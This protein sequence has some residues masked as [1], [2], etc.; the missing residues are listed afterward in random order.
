MTPLLRDIGY[1]FRVIR[2]A[3]GFTAIIVLTLALG[4]GA[5][6]AIFSVVNAVLL[7]PFPF[8][9]ADRLV[10]TWEVTPAPDA[11]PMFLS[12][13]NYLDWRDLNRSLDQLAAFA[14]STFFL[15][16]DEETIR[17]DGTRI[18][19]NLLET[20]GVSPLAGRDFGPDDDAPDAAPV[21]LISYALWQGR[22]GGDPGVVGRTIQLDGIAYEVVGVMGADFA[23]PPPIDLEGNTLPRDNDVWVPFGADMTT[24]QRSAHFVTGIGRLA[25]GATLETA[26]ADLGAVAAQLA[27]DWPDSNEGWSARVVP[28][29]DVVLGNM[30]PALLVLLAAVTAVLLIACVNV[31]NLLLSRATGRQKEYAIRAALG[32]RRQRLVSQA[33]VESQILA[34]IGGGAGIVLA[35]P[36]TR[37]LIRIAPGNVPRLDQAG[38]DPVVIGWAL[39]LS[40][41]TGLLYGLAPA[42]RS[43]APDLVH[44]LKEG[45]R[46]SVGDGQGRLRDSLV[47]A[48]VALSLLLL[49]GAGLLFRSFLQ[50]RGIDPGFRAEQVLTMR[51][52][53]PRTY[54]DGA[55][56]AAAFA[57]I[58]ER[59]RA[60]PGV[61]AAGFSLDLPLANDY[62]GTTLQIEGD[63]P[64]ADGT[65]LV[66]FSYVT[67]GWFDAMGIPVTSGRAIDATDVADSEPTIVINAA[68]ARAWFDGDPVGRRILFGGSRRVVGVVGDVRLESIA[69]V[70][71]PAMYVPYYQSPGN[72][73]LSLVLRSRADATT[74][75]GSIR[76]GVRAVDAG[77]PISDIRA[78]DDVVA[79][80]LASPRFASIVLIAFSLAALFL[81]AIGIYGVIS[82]ATSVRIREIGVRMALGA[83]PADAMTLVVRHAL[84]LALSGV[85]IGVIASLVFTR[86]LSSL[87]FGVRPTDPLTLAAVAAFLVAVAVVAGGV[88]AWK[89]SR[90]D[91]L[92]ALRSE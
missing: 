56:R 42:V 12:P 82:Y 23:F 15:A 58:E 90:V 50:L 64:P 18:S 61:D 17:V 75:A 81:A 77:I 53:L 67:P 34:L 65:N 27:R 47:I 43:F 36:A 74:L 84:R 72:R 80:A 91:P 30:R 46:S 66:H 83:R 35:W 60:L 45:G 85:V 7:R 5:N 55:A 79:E 39:G 3:P 89:A 57:D 73:G 48:E 59:V 40:V 38:I 62:Q 86:F 63:P 76:D 16:N 70:A 31:A 21:A 2:K 4:I 52:T 54:E 78:M 44:W 49:A 32:A 24:G 1:A 92:D 22:F 14:P 20:L 29:D 28:M 13:P 69:D 6:T 10:V 8:E 41:L 11:G 71:R 68:A 33:I 37:L 26:N 87:L 25:D 9:E 51:V 19:A 88:P